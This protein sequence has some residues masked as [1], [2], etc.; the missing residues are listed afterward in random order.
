MLELVPTS[1]T[2]SRS[3]Q[4]RHLVASFAGDT[5]NTTIYLSRLGGRVAY[6]TA[7]GDDP[8]SRLLVG[9]TRTEGVDVELISSI[10]NRQLGLY[11]I[12][13]LA[14]GER[15]FR[16]WRSEA[17]ARE[18]LSETF[19]QRNQKKIFA[20]PNLFLSGI[21]IAILKDGGQ[22]R[23]LA[24]L[25]AYREQGGTIYFDS[26]YRPILW[27]DAELAQSTTDAVLQLSNV[28]LL[29][30]EDQRALWKLDS[31]EETLE[32]CFEIDVPE[33]VI[34]RGGQSTLVKFENTVYEVDTP[35]VETII[36]TTGAGDSFNAGYIQ[37]R[38]QNKSCEDA[39][40]Q[41]NRCAGLVIQHR[42]AIIPR[43]EF[44][45]QWGNSQENTE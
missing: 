22:Q 35:K 33:I 32:R 25:K 1:D 38:L 13:N 19:I 42:G 4:M 3:K 30:L 36:D 10:P 26:N 28:A 39:V 40:V 5:Y 21:S 23:L 14:D 45:E 31:D 8:Y 16:Y 7:V 17:P 12:R 41:A 43:E 2:S 15:E 44:I 20:A 9:N 29:T 37:A 6:C 27:P 24:F 18:L 11:M 34:K